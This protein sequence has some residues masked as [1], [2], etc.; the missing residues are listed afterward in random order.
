MNGIMEWITHWPRLRN[1][2]RRLKQIYRDNA[3]STV[4]RTIHQMIKAKYADEIFSRD[5]MASL[6][7]R[8]RLASRVYTSACF[9]VSPIR[10]SP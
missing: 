3:F 4:R 9:K 7:K 1:L 5:S 2:A 10:K 6:E 8:F